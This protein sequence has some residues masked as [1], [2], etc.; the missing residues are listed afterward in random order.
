MNNFIH[1]LRLFKGMLEVA[2]ETSWDYILPHLF[3]L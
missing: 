1:K 2:C 3:K